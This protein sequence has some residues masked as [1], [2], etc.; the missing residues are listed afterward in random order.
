MINKVIYSV[1]NQKNDND[2][3]PQYSLKPPKRKKP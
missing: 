2:K 3:S 1:S